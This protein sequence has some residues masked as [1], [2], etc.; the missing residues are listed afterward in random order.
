MEVGDIIVTSGLSTVYPKNLPVGE[1]VAVEPQD[2]NL[3]F[4]AVVRP[5]VDFARL[6]YVL[7]V[8]PQEQRGEAA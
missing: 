7:I 8:L 2:Y 6:E 5:F 4:S 3:S 1:V